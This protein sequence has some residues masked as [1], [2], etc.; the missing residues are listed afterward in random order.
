MIKLVKS[1]EKFFDKEIYLVN[2]ATK[3]GITTIEPC[4]YCGEKHAYRFDSPK[5][6]WESNRYCIAIYDCKCP[7]CNKKFEFKDEFDK[8]GD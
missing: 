7:S 2:G 1:E 5:I 6:E 4:P 3:F 8:L